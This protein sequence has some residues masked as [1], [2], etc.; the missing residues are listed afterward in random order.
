V[1]QKTNQRTDSL[2]DLVHEKSADILND[3]GFCVPEPAALARLES[4]GFPVDHDSQMVRV[5]PELLQTALA[6]LNRDVKLYDR[7]GKTAV[8]Y[9]QHSCFMGAGTPVHVF[10]LETG[11]HRHAATF[12]KPS[13][14]AELFTNIGSLASSAAIITKPGGQKARQSKR[15]AGKRPAEF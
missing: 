10:D 14:P 13:I 5:P 15:F 7:K 3:V 6:G 11:K 12:S 2:T 4:A 9:R 8:P 1:I